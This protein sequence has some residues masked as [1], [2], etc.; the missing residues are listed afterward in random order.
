MKLGM[1]QSSGNKIFKK[2]IH[3]SINMSKQSKLLEFEL[4]NLKVWIPY[5]DFT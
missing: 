3:D 2:K 5:L 1:Q 4:H